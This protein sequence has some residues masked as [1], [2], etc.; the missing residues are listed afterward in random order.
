[1]EAPKHAY[2]SKTDSMVALPQL[3][4]DSATLPEAR[5]LLEG[6]AL[7]LGVPVAWIAFSDGMRPCYV[8]AIDPA[9]LTDLL[10]DSTL[11]ADA[12]H[13][14]E[15]V[16]VTDVA[17]EPRFLARP[18]ATG[19][20]GMRF[21]AAAPI[22]LR[23]LQ[24]A[25]TLCVADRSARTLDASQTNGLV[26]VAAMAAR[27]IESSLAIKRESALQ[28][29][30]QRTKTLLERTGSMA[31]VGGWEVDLIANTIFWSDETC[32]IHG[33][34][35]GYSPQLNEAIEFY[36]PQARP[37]IQAAVAHAIATGQGWDLELP[38]IQ[39]DGTPIWVRAMGVAEF[40]QGQPARLVGAF[41]D[42]TARHFAEAA[43]TISESQFRGS[44]Q[45]ASHGIALVSNL[46]KFLKVNQ[47]L[48]NILGYSEAELLATDF[49]TI[50]HPDD[51]ASDLQH[52][53]D[54]LR[55]DVET[56][57]MEKRYFHKDGRTIWVQLS[58]SLVRTPDGTPV[59]FVS[60]IQDINERKNL[61]ARLQTLLDTA[62]DGIH[63]LDRDGYVLQFSQSFV[64]MLGY[65]TAETARLNVRDWDAMIEPQEL[66]PEI[67]RLMAQPRAFETKFR[68]KDGII[69]EV[70]INAK[71]VVLD[72]VDFLYASARDITARKQAERAVEQ[73]RLFAQDIL[74]SVHSEIAVLNQSGIIVA[75]NLAWRQFA[76]DNGGCLDRASSK[77]VDIGAN[78]FAALTSVPTESG[79]SIN[80][81]EGVE[82]V[83]N[84][85]MPNFRCEYPCHS[86]E[87]K[88]WFLMT[89][90][91]MH[92]GD[93]GAVIV[94]ADIT[95]RKEAE[96]LMY[97]YAF[98][99]SLTRLA[100]RRLLQ[101]RLNMNIASNK[102]SGAYGAL[103][104][105]DLDNF[106]PLNDNMAM[107]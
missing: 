22:V 4:S 1:M 87:K 107:Q 60:Q 5:P 27:I 88:R 33:V 44:F 69:L 90:S 23:D 17:L 74:D 83:V 31:G 103:L 7:M 32:R 62:S 40:E 65:T 73:G 71:G 36:A 6:V 48:C 2:P 24:R 81:R 16:T 95:A 54:L 105:I 66:I 41:Q 61:T 53:Q 39:R 55:G 104:V 63:I 72:G 70:E 64:L 91:P 45:A 9:V 94:H 106:K 97:D 11:L 89:V 75:T 102:R 25:G 52:V 93:R 56:Y 13:G 57:D 35:K 28:L 34:P 37:V 49:Q 10:S 67:G 82:S 77:N 20:A 8:A 14:D 30:L 92:T 68:R 3:R 100:N 26:A 99:D 96:A 12:S 38:F 19:P 21:F 84:G 42:I 76:I 101:E 58:V 46:G 79:E 98:H 43:L 80:I 85:K 51:L 18:W 59:H 29:E 50:T 86:P 47:S 78:Y 15:L